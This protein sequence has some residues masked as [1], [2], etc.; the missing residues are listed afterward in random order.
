[1]MKFY[2]A[3]SKGWESP[4]LWPLSAPSS[5]SGSAWCQNKFT[6]F[7]FWATEPHMAEM[8]GSRVGE[9]GWLTSAGG[10]HV[11][12]LPAGQALGPSSP[13]SHIPRVAN[14]LD[15]IIEVKL[16]ALSEAVDRVAWVSTS[17][18]CN[19]NRR[20]VSP[21][22]IPHPSK[23]IHLSPG[24]SYAHQWSSALSL[25]SLSFAVKPL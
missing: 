7:F 24:M 15:H 18:C 4:H 3:L 12:P 8:V 13:F 25:T 10:Q 1:M 9:K 22:T 19:Q 23:F 14:K 2:V 20:Y 6:G 17:N 11:T 16:V 21:P 5:L